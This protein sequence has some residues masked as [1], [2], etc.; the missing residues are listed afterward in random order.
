MT[1][2]ATATGTTPPACPTDL[3]TATVTTLTAP[4]APAVSPGQ[5]G[6]PRRPTV[7]TAGQ[8]VSIAYAY[9]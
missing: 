2:T 7:S 1:D 8:G 6:L 4:A 5:D 9:A 3:G